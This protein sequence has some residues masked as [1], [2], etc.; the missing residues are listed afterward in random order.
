M[1]VYRPIQ[2]D[3]EE[4]EDRTQGGRSR[5]RTAR[6]VQL[7]RGRR[8]GGNTCEGLTAHNERKAAE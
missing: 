6:A 1:L 5:I 3:P 8:K 7:R 2:R 4:Q